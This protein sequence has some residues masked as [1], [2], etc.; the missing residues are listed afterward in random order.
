MVTTVLLVVASGAIHL[1]YRR[2]DAPAP[3]VSGQGGPGL[4]SEYPALEAWEQRVKQIGHGTPTPMTAVEALEI[5]REAAPQTP[6]HADP[7][8]PQ[9]LKI[10]QRVSV[11]PDLDSGEPAVAGTVRFVDRHRIAILREDPQVGHVCVH[12]PRLGYRVRVE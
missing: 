7:R 12:F 8:D 2:R 5:A 6:E 9:G 3:T 4:L 10:G 11:I 1:T